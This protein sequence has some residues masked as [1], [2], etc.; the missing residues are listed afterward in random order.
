VAASPRKVV[1][2]PENEVDVSWTDNIPPG[3]IFTPTVEEFQNPFQYLSK[4][5]EEA[6][7]YGILKIIPPVKPAVPAGQV[8]LDNNFQFTTNVQHLG[9]HKPDGKLLRKKKFYRSGTLYTLGSYQAMANEAMSKTF[10][11]CG[12]LP[13]GIVEKE[14]WKEMYTVPNN[15]SVEYG[16]DI[17]GSAFSPSPSCPLADSNWNLKAFARSSSSSLTHLDEQIP[18]VTDPMLYCGMLFSQFAWHVEDCSLNSINYH[19]LGS[20]KL[21]YGVPTE[22]AGKF[23]E[24]AYRH[25][26]NQQNGKRSGEKAGGHV[27]S[28]EMVGKD[29]AA[30]NFM[31]KTTMFSP[32]YLLD[33]DVK[34]YK[35]VQQPGEFVITFPQAYHGGFSTGFNLGEAVN[36][37]TIEWFKYGIE[38]E[39]RYQRLKKVPV[40][41]LEEILCC[42]LEK[43]MENAS[44]ESNEMWEYSLA[45]LKDAWNAKITN[46][47]EAVGLLGN[48]ECQILEQPE[49]SP[50]QPCSI[51][52][53]MCHIA[54]FMLGDVEEPICANCVKTEA[55]KC[56]SRKR[57][58]KKKLR[59]SLSVN[60]KAKKISQFLVQ[61]D[62]KKFEVLRPFLERLQVAVE[63]DEYCEVGKCAGE[64]GEYT[65]RLVNATVWGAVPEPVKSNACTA[66]RS[67]NLE[68]TTDSPSVEGKEG[69]TRT[70][71]KVKLQLGSPGKSIS[72]GEDW[73]GHIKCEGN[74]APATEMK[75]QGLPMLAGKYLSFMDPMIDRLG[76]ENERRTQ[77]RCQAWGAV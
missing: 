49:I 29:K 36:F 33:N 43:R 51:C 25:L 52:A 37:A 9:V 64:I 13:S 6:S 42:D 26:F 71:L 67:M 58:Q 7:K 28:Q 32:K 75:V 47:S 17:D 11:C 44:N 3:P 10:G 8:L 14:F 46:L 69:S 40:V 5:S 55:A 35:I 54:F 48:D 76:N 24:V 27:V 34:V 23:D 70:G 41:S 21:W 18:G 63:G 56:V 65:E 60:P 50:S 57:P 12:T 1:P 45:R 22:D 16:S 31:A 38:A 72:G 4:I 62:P 77:E 39:K 59:G 53:G 15:K 19:H 2:S 30:S 66:K 61:K 68:P 20:P 73:E 74:Q